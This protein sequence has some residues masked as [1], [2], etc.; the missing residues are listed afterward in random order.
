MMIKI[1]ATL[2]DIIPKTLEFIPA[3]V[4]PTGSPFFGMI[5]TPTPIRTA[6]ITNSITGVFFILLF[7]IKIS[8]FCMAA[9]NT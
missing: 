3:I 4:K 1:P 5:L 2:N 7:I 8:T 6:A 9:S